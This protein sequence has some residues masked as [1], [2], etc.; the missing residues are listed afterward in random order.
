MVENLLG[1]SAALLKSDFIA[2]TMVK[3]RHIVWANDA[4][5]CIFGYEPGELIGQPTRNLYPDEESYEAFGREA[6]SVLG[7]GET[8][9]GTFPQ[10]RKDGTT[11]WYE[12]HISS[13]PGHPEFTVGA[14]V[15]RTDSYLAIQQIE[16]S[17]SRYRSVVEDQTEVIS[18]FLPD[19]TFVFVNEVFC[20]VFGKTSDELIGQRWQPGVAHPDDVSMVEGKLREMSPNHPVVTI[21]NRVFVADGEMRWMQ[22]VNRGFY[23]VNGTLTEIQAVGRDITR[24]KQ[25]EYS[26]RKSEETLNRAQSVARIGSF[27]MNSDTETFSMT[28]ETARLFGLDDTGVTTFAEWFSRVHPDDQR[29][30]NTAWRAALQGSP[31]DMTY[32]I[33]VEGQIRWI[34]ALAE[35]QF[36]DHGLLSNAVGT[37]Q[38]ITD[39]KQTEIALRESDERLELALAGSG[40]VSWDWNIPER[41]ISAGNRLYELLGYQHEE[42]GND[43][44][45]WMNFI[46]P[47][48][49]E[50]VKQTLASH[51][52]GETADFESEHR[53]RHKDGHWVMVESK[54]KVTRRDKD[55]APLRMVGTMRDITQRKRLNE[56]GVKLLQQIESLIRETSSNSPGKAEPDNAA[57]SLTKRQRQVLGM[58]AN[59]MTSAEIGKQLNLATPTI[60]SH[61]RNLMAKL[62]LHSTAEVTRFAINHG[63]IT[64]T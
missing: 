35:L 55:N 13:L 33:V 56:E 21:E 5:H 22:F 39:L 54:G 12:F 42:L 15:D 20:R 47:K 14:I 49:L 48:D 18:R 58:I 7:R 52:Q 6:Y 41:Q 1:Q 45:D 19:G 23:D 29:P 53:L 38:D 17:E 16:A 32:R 28:H 10:Q 25:I 27:A 4:M 57:E 30:V 24:L 43:A 26:L 46:H 44:D 2:I 31:Y 36:D 34:R 8:Y 3:E 37:V 40:M 61:R 62:N 63:L 50:L 9:S 11:G 59:G 51:L 64:T 60:I